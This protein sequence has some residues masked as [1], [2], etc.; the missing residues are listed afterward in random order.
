MLAITVRRGLKPH[1]EVTKNPAILP[2]NQPPSR[3]MF[4]GPIA[5][6]GLCVDIPSRGVHPAMEITS[7]RRF[8]WQDGYGCFSI[9]RSEL[10]PVK[11]YVSN[12]KKHHYEK[13]IHKE[14]ED[15]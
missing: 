2:E 12:Q 7:R 4:L 6:R 8:Y 14:L 9:G 10:I 3:E 5:Q 13:A 11:A 1:G 15:C